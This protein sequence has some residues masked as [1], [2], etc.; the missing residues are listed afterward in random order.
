M[1][2]FWQQLMNI[3]SRLE[4]AQKATIVLAG[5]GFL[6]LVGTLSITASQPDYRLLA[7]GLSKSQVAEIVA[8]LES[9]HIPY[10]VADNESAVMVPSQYLYKTRNEL[11][12]Q[13]L[14]GDGSRGFEIL[15]KSS[16]MWES[17]FSEH[18]TYDRAVGGELER[19]FRELPGVR[20]ARVLID[21]PQPSP[22]AGDEEAKPKASIKLDMTPG[23]R[24]SERQIAGVI[25][26]TAG[27]IAGLSPDR[28]EVMD[29]SGLLTPKA[30]D[31]TA[32]LAQTTLEAETARER[33]LTRKAQEQLDTVLGPGR[34]QV[35]VSVKLDFTKR[36]ESS[37]DPGKRE[38]LEE[39]T[40]SSDEKNETANAGGV[41]GTA[42]NA[43]GEARPAASEPL[44]GSKTREEANNKYVV[45]KKTFTQEDE[46]GRIKGMNVSIL[47]PFRQIQKPKLDDNG[48][49]TKE[50][51]TV[52]EEYPQT[53]KD[54]FKELVLNTIGFNSAKD[55]AAK[56]ENAANL[57]NRFT[58]SVQSME[59]YKSPE[60]EVTVAAISLPLTSIPWFDAAGYGVAGLVA[61]AIL[62]VAR[63]QL[64]RSHM[65][66]KEAEERARQAMDAEQ[67]KNAPPAPEETE[68][69]RERVVLKQRRNGLRDQI[70][71][72]IIE[73]PAA[74]AQIVRKWL[75]EN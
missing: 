34:S 6:I 39:H 56:L 7:K 37:S 11:A 53:E 17:T 12:Q 2:K 69:D 50:M 67:K 61:L 38:L 72:K 63:G 64:K 23:M 51:E 75:Y 20:S 74:A 19:S 73:D 46:V 15:G 48:K 52:S 49:P 41:A 31:S 5:L 14:L 30:G 13:D 35:Q 42:P 65:A 54:R 25:H 40:N 26:L 9:N 8:N 18:K 44:R 33:Y 71:K 62:F 57:D 21:R 4:I 55:I 58:S 28:V 59:L 45:G 32:M 3:W 29:S 43:E 70:K 36:T 22:F 60:T 16:S 1:S 66:W 68:E 27:A 10:Q 47:L 24:L